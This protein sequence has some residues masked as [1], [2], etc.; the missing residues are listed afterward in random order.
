MSSSC[1]SSQKMAPSATSKNSKP[2]QLMHMTHELPIAHL[3][4]YACI[5]F[6][7]LLMLPSIY[8]FSPAAFQSSSPWRLD[9]PRYA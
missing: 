5:F 2:R 3:H 9:R 4:L 8:A 6:V 7:Q 1:V